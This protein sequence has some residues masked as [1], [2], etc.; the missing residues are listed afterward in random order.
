MDVELSGTPGLLGLVN[1]TG[2]EADRGLA[3]AGIRGAGLS[4]ES[5]AH[6]R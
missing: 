1:E 5:E 6:L 2:E 4:P 3:V